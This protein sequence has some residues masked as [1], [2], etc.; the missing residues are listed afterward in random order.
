MYVMSTAYLPCCRSYN[1]V[2]VLFSLTAW[3]TYYVEEIDTF[4]FVSLKSPQCTC[5]HIVIAKFSW[6]VRDDKFHIVNQIAPIYTNL[7]VSLYYSVV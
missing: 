3:Q 2:L 7:L 4:F 1:I 5:I 6:D